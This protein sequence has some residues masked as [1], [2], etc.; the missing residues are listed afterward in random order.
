MCIYIDEHIHEP[1]HDVEKIYDYLVMLSYMLAAKKRYFHKEEDYDKFSNYL[2]TIVYNRMTTQRQFLAET[3]PMYLTPIKSCLNYMK[4]IIYARKCAYCDE[5]FNYATLV[6][7]DESNIVRDYM[8]E[9]VLATPNDLL[10]CDIEIYLGTIDK[11]VKDIL[12]NG[13]YAN[14]KILI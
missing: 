9:Q 2:A 11:I 14:D 5:E 8:T 7:S 13:V 10:H 4:N 3:D 6:N 12:N 1:N